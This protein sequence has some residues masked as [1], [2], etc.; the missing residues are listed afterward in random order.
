MR[1]G[2]VGVPDYGV[3]FFEEFVVERWAVAFPPSA[4]GIVALKEVIQ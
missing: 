1:Y 4:M 2:R 3:C